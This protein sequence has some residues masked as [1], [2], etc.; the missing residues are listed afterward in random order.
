[1]GLYDEKVQDGP[2]EDSL[3]PREGACLDQMHD[4]DKGDVFFLLLVKV[5]KM[6]K[7]RVAMPP[8]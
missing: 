2:L 7:E 1:M 6:M 5:K 8:A 3:N 4:H